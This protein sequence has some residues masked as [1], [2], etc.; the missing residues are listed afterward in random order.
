MEHTELTCVVHVH[1][2]HSDGTGTID[3]IAQAAGRAGA[4]AVLV[5]D[6]DVTAGQA[7]AGWHGSVL[8]GV[9]VEV[10]P[11][12]GSHLLA[13][14]LQQ[15][16]RHLGRTLG[17]VL[18]VV[19]GAGGIGF[20]AHPFSRGGWLLGRAGRAAPFGD[21]RLPVDGIE[22]WSLV[23]DTLERIHTPWRL[24][25]FGRDPDAVLVDPP[26]AN[27]AAW[28]ALSAARATPAIGGLDAHQYGVRR[29]GRVLVRTM[30][31]ER[32]FALLRTHVL[33]DGPV[34]GDAPRDTAALLAALARGRAFLARDSLAD[35]TGF[36]LRGETS[37]GAALAMGDEAPHAGPAE[38][39][40]TAPADCELRL[41]RDGI[42]IASAPGARRLRHVAR[43]PGVYRVSAHREH[44]GRARTWVLT[45]PIHLR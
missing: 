8:V 38:L 23:T 5:T 31:Y 34:S 15:P 2:L 35:A 7:E 19:H 24:V 37:E 9:G 25:R 13:F 18:D 16:V 33:L 11:G 40:A 21:L 44:R 43:E 29:R 39:V 3:E 1:S 10:S 27:L 41:L 12:H 14:G 28:D 17:Q 6:H 36:R 4:D 22:L 42:V 32:S 20:A 26:A 45:N 30:A